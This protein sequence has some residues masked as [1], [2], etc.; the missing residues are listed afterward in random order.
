M[1]AASRGSFS[2]SRCAG[3]ASRKRSFAPRVS[4]Q[5]SRYSRFTPASPLLVLTTRCHACHA[6]PR[7]AQPAAPSSDAQRA[8]PRAAMTAQGRHPKVS[9][10]CASRPCGCPVAA[11]M[12]PRLFRHVRQPASPA[13][14]PM[15]HR[16]KLGMFWV[17]KLAEVGSWR[18]WRKPGLPLRLHS[19]RRGSRRRASGRPRGLAWR[20]GSVQSPIAPALNTVRY[21]AKVLRVFTDRCSPTEIPTVYLPE[22]QAGS[23]LATEGSREQ[24]PR[25]QSGAQ[26]KIWERGC[27]ESASGPSGT[28]RSGGCTGCARQPK[29]QERLRPGTRLPPPR[30]PR[31]CRRL[32]G[33]FRVGGAPACAGA[34]PRRAWNGRPGRA[35]EGRGS[36]RLFPAKKAA[37]WAP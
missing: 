8:P 19:H 17:R 3:L 20:S 21:F 7:N 5:R 33:A 24:G 34:V 26:A 1:H 9:A 32:L 15:A 14:P 16:T 29:R 10:V 35:S 13:M 23:A 25:R 11:K 4:S 18:G 2:Y 36:R 37:V 30:L 6:A 12:Q 31:R 27:R 22:A 28:S